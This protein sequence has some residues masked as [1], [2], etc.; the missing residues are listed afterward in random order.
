MEY[1]IPSELR[2]KAVE[3]SAD[4]GRVLDRLLKAEAEYERDKEHVYLVSM[5]VRNTI[6]KIEL[7]GLGVLDSVSI[8]PREVFRAAILA[9]ANTV[10]LAHSHPSG[11]V[12]PSTPDILITARLAEV[13]NIIGI[14]LVDHLILD[15]NAHMF[16]MR[17]IAEGSNG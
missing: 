14:P 17:A 9:G 8:H 5:S 1:D 12:E 16:S 7:I 4:I 15:G 11:N 3:G 6:K 10:Y 2:D 13:G